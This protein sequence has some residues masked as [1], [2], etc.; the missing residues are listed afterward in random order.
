MFLTRHHFSCCW[1]FKASSD[2]SKSAFCHLALSCKI[3]LFATFHQASCSSSS[4]VPSPSPFSAQGYYSVIT[5]A[6][7]LWQ[8]LTTCNVF[9]SNTT[10]AKQRLAV[11]WGWDAV[12]GSVCLHAGDC[13]LS[14]NTNGN[15]TQLSTICF[16]LC[17]MWLQSCKGIF[18]IHMAELA[19]RAVGIK[20]ASCMLRTQS[21]PLQ[22][23]SFLTV[24]NAAIC[25]TSGSGCEWQVA[26]D[27][28]S[29]ADVTPLYQHPVYSDALQDPWWCLNDT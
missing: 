3:F 8:L 1:V 12:I 18:L 22:M 9:H 7:H 21:K 14:V 23:S 17:Q 24:F 5:L 25:V 19:S 28:L 15:E 20:T 16:L 6:D 27:N 11:R 13:F 26:S 4:L 29:H 10:L 2:V